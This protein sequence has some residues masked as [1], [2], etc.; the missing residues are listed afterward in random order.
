M[1]ETSTDVLLIWHTFMLNPRDYLG[2]CIRHGKK[3]LWTDG[4]PW[5]A[6]NASI[7]NETFE[8]ETSQEAR[9]YFESRTKQP[10]DALNMP[11]TIEI[12]CLKCS[13]PVTCEWTTCDNIKSWTVSSPGEG[14][15]GFAEKDFGKFCP[16]CNFMMCHER[17]KV[18]R[19]PSPEEP[20]HSYAW[21][22][23]GSE[24]HD[25]PVA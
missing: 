20:R 8:Y 21:Y 19:C 2:D 9:E 15:L 4:F 25:W 7:N 12:K 14:G 1:T 13:N 6:V 10:Y 24:R 3:G 22:T 18:Q 17:L 11:S 23:L 16:S 5:D